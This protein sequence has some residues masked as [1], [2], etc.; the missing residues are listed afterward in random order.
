MFN[1]KEKNASKIRIAEVPVAT[2]ISH[3]NRDRAVTKT[4]AMNMYFKSDLNVK[5]DS[6]AHSK[7]KDKLM[8]SFQS[9]KE[10]ENDSLAKTTYGS[11]VRSSKITAQVKCTS[12]V[13][14]KRLQIETSAKATQL[15][16]QEQFHL[17]TPKNDSLK[18]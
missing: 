6:V 8:I 13:P 11:L 18:N 15:R 4:D 10:K 7:S 12:A 14:G 16:L 1:K 9:R 5:M 2:H 3:K 17:L